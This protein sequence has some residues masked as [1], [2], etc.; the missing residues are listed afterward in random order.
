MRVR[1]HK[2]EYARRIARGLA[3][4]L[5]RSQ[6][7]GHPKSAEAPARTSSRPIS[8]DRIQRAFRVLR[9]ERSFAEAARAA[10]VSPERLRNYAIERGLIEKHG[11]RWQTRADLPRRMLIFSIGKSLA[12][13]VVELTPKILMKKVGCVTWT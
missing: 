10:K 12:V 6:A 9:Q 2:T 8:D 1:D 5:S 13:T 7:R 11:R 4:G 3:S